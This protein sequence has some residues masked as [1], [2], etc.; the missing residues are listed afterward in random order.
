MI[1]SGVLKSINSEVSAAKHAKRG[2]AAKADTD[3]EPETKKGS[4]VKF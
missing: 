2:S 1:F 4:P 3:T